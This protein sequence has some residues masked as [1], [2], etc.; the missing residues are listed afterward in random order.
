MEAKY[1]HD[2]LERAE[3]MFQDGR[4][5]AWLAVVGEVARGHRQDALDTLVDLGTVGL[6]WQI[7][8]GRKK[9]EIYQDFGL[10]YFWVFTRKIEAELSR[11][12]GVTAGGVR[13]E[14]LGRRTVWLEETGNGKLDRLTLICGAKSVHLGPQQSRL[15][16]VLMRE[17]GATSDEKL[18]SELFSAKSLRPGNWEAGALNSLKTLVCEANGRIQ[19]GLGT[20]ATATD[21]RWIERQQGPPYFLSHRV[22][23]RYRLLKDFVFKPATADPRGLAASIHDF[24]GEQHGE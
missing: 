21:C 11:R 19:F 8:S 4:T 7:A 17:G 20:V 14:A 10:E 2:F 5:K 23:W 15:V 1:G 9:V 22:I 6:E 12:L 13:V 3:K 24:R 16:K 18:C